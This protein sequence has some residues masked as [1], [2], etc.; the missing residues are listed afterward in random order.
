MQWRKCLFLGIFALLLRSEVMAEDP[1]QLVRVAVQTELTA[2]A[3]D[4]TRWIYFETDRK[5]DRTVKQW[6]AE[7]REGNLHR[8]TELNGQPVAESDQRKKMDLFVQ[9]PSSRSKQKKNE[10]HDDEQ[11]A[12]LLRLLPE[13]FNWTYRGNHDGNDLLHFVPNPQFRPPDFESKV[14]ASME[15]DMIVN[16]RDHRIVTL[17]GTLIHDVKIFGGIFGSLNSG[18]TFDVERRMTGDS[19]WQITETHVHIIGH[20]L[21][22]KTISEQEDDVKTQFKELNGTLDATLRQ[23]ENDLLAQGK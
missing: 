20:I 16:T 1:R 4:H 2:D 18:G 22:F 21:L 6:V 19:V 5:P 15:G 7:T 9:D 8:V 13:A 23:A 3:N 14:F 11:A 10:Q 17:K 12:E